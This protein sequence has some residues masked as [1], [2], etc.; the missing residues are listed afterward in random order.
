MRNLVAGFMYYMTAMGLCMVSSVSFYLFV[1][2]LAGF[3]ECFC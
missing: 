1:S 2:Y 3:N